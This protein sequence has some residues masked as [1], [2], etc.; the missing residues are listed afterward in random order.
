MLSDKTHVTLCLVSMDTSLENFPSWPRPLEVLMANN[1]WKDF[2]T[3]KTKARLT[4]KSNTHLIKVRWVRHSGKITVDILEIVFFWWCVIPRVFLLQF[5]LM[6]RVYFDRFESHDECSSYQP[7][8]GASLASHHTHVFSKVTQ[9]LCYISRTAAAAGGAIPP[10]FFLPSST[11]KMSQTTVSEERN[12]RRNVT[13][14][15]WLRENTG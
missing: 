5:I 14:N 9:T 7:R 4:F 8:S 12:L 6:I 10:L 13:L 15:V 2:V 3:S 1:K 11:Y